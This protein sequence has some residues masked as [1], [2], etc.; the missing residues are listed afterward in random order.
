MRCFIS[1]ICG[2][3]GSELA[4]R[5]REHGHMVSGTD[6][7]MRAGSRLNRP[8]LEELGVEVWEGDIRRQDD[9][10]RVKSVDWVVDAA[11][12]P[13]V[14]AG[15][16][17]GPQ[18][19]LEHNLW[20][21]VNLLEMCRRASAGLVLLSTSRV[22]SIDALRALPI[23]TDKNRFILS[24]ETNL[25]GLAGIKE[26]FPTSAPISLYGAS[27]LSSEILT[28]EYGITFGF[29]VIINRCGVMAGAGQ[30]GR[31]DQGIFSFW[32]HSW[33][34]RSRLEFIG[35]NG[36]GCQVRDCLHPS[37]L[38]ELLLLQMAEQRGLVV[39]V[40]GGA[41]SAISLAQLSEWC[42]HRF[43]ALDVSAEKTNRQFDVPW[44]VL[45]HE[46]C[47]STWGWR[48]SRK[49]WSIMSEIADHAERHP[50]WLSISCAQ[51]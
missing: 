23:A 43:G 41:D 29:P 14:L 11:A 42:G 10:K 6:N 44:C 46:L 7:F 34:G 27:K 32:I 3:V 35:F 24:Q 39:N 45:S 33:V 49:V 5:F 21:T 9:L 30:F 19:L 25:A 4:I 47:T 28:Q 1:G 16:S 12:N 48:P 50:E 8:R 37:D 13:S 22:Y 36:T 38:A 26:D 20:G 2:F 15:L 40:S 51:N 31:P 17:G 18:E